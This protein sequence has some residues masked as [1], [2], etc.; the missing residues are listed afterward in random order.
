M[1]IR[2]VCIYLIAF[3]VL[4]IG[5]LLITEPVK[6]ATYSGRCGKDVRWSLD[7][8]TGVLEIYGTGD[9]YDNALTYTSWRSCRSQIKTIKIAEGVTSI[10]ERAFDSCENL[11]T[12]EMGEG[13]VRIG[14]YAF[15]SCYNNIDRILFC[16]VFI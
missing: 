2:K 9:M 8:E 7:T 12:V 1:K 13:L 6:A 3:A 14:N 11:T 16:E 5:G 10:S 4:L 15:F